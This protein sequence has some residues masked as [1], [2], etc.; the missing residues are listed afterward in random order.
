MLPPLG[1]NAPAGPAAPPLA[2]PAPGGLQQDVNADGTVDEKDVL[3]LE[4]FVK[5]LKS[6]IKKKSDQPI[7]GPQD[8]LSSQSASQSAELL[9][10]KFEEATPNFLT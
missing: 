10:P 1:S 9:N 3:L 8:V 2:A 7:T 5:M 6:I 4:D